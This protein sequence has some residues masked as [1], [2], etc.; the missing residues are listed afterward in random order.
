MLRHRLKFAKLNSEKT[1]GTKGLA[2][3]GFPIS[4]QIVKNELKDQRIERSTSVDTVP[5]EKAKARLTD[6]QRRQLV[7][8]IREVLG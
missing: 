3:T 6:L 5:E 1:Y 2:P 7:A 4:A 8:A